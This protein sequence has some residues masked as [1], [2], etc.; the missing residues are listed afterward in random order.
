MRD[1]WGNK[2]Q[3]DPAVNGGLRQPTFVESNEDLL[4][5]LGGMAAAAGVTYAACTCFGEDDAPKAA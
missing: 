4:W 5:I 2:L 1:P 3:I